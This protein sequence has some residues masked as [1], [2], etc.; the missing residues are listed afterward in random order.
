MKGELIDAEE[1][2]KSAF[3]S[4][5]RPAIREWRQSKGLGAEPLQAFRASGYTDQAA[6]ARG[7]KNQGAVASYA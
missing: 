4:D 3:S 5:V 1:C 7:K 2:L 6:R